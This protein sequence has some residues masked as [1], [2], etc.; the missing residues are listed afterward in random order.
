MNIQNVSWLRRLALPILQICAVDFTMAHPWNTGVRV[1][2]NSFRHKGYWWHRKRREGPTMELFSRLVEPGDKIVE[3]GGHIGFISTYF[4]ALVGERGLVYVFEPGVNNLPYIRKNV[5]PDLA[6]RHATQIKLVEMAVGERDGTATFYEDSLT[7]QNNSLVQ[8]FAGLKRNQKNSF[9]RSEVVPRQVQTVALDSYFSSRGGVDFIKV[10]IEGYEW[11]AIR[12]ASH[13]IAQH[14]P[15][16]MIEIQASRQELFEFLTERNYVLFDDSI[17]IK[18]N[19]SELNGNIFC[20]HREK[21]ETLI[22]ELG[23]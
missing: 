20:L 5:S 14:Q 17:R 23:L 13:I 6:P 7:G 18:G 10:D 11:G 3:V 8:D 2:L 4:A 9:V 22:Q 21:H 15:K 12:G 1:Y 16:M 19:S